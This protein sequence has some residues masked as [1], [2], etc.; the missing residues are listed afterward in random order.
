MIFLG[1]E[2]IAKRCNLRRYLGISGRGQLRLV[3][4]FRLFGGFIL[5]I[6]EGI[7]RRS[8]LCASMLLYDLA[9]LES[10]KHLLSCFS[11]YWFQEFTEAQSGPVWTSSAY[12]ISSLRTPLSSHS[13]HGP[14]LRF[15]S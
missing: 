8:I 15:A 10:P 4:L 1:V 3:G 13:V 6:V 12:V 5:C 11:L 9:S 2:E 7:D 14:F